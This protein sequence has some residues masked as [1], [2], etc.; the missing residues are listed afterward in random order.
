[1]ADFTGKVVLITGCG[2]GQGRAACLAFAAHGATVVGCD[3]DAASTNETAAQLGAVGRSMDAAAGVDLGD[4]EQARV[5][6]ERA[7]A[8]HGRIDIVYNNGSS[9]RFGPVGSMSIEDWRYT[10]RNEIDLVFYVTRYAW[11]FL[12]VQGGVIINVA[13]V[14]GHGA[15]RSA[16]I[17]A[18]AAA[19]GAIIALTRQMAAEGAPHGIRAVSISPGVIETPGTRD[20]LND[21]D[22]RRALL[23]E[24]LLPRP[25]QPEEVVALALFL[26]SDAAGFITGSDVIIDGGRM[27][28]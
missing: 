16:P 28:T 18:H 25:G 12:E 10:M 2:G 26:A 7:A 8:T 19:K 20:M 27:T 23:S 1:M 6:V 24:S 15:S 5:W 11:R 22:L 17:A 9:A 21:P 4:P 13:S 3:I 14:A